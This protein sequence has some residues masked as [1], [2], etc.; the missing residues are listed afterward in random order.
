MKDDKPLFLKTL[1]LKLEKFI[2]K[3]K[4]RPPIFSS[5]EN[6]DFLLDKLISEGVSDFVY[7]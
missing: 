7:K 3:M 2:L 1:F 4:N 5:T 6:I